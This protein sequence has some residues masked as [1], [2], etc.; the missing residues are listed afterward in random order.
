MLGTSSSCAVSK[1]VGN[2]EVLF[3]ALHNS[4]GNIRLSNTPHLYLTGKS[5]MSGKVDATMFT[6]SRRCNQD[7]R[8]LPYFLR[9]L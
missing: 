9:E 5:A 7:S 8:R 6:F 1:D 3:V 4:V 2:N